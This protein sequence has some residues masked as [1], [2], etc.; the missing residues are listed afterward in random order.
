MRMKILTLVSV[1]SIAALAG[2]SSVTASTP[3]F[4]SDDPLLREPEPQDA[5]GAAP[6]Y[7]DLM[8]ELTYNLFALPRHKPSGVRAQNVN[9]IDEVPD[10]SWFTNRI[11]T[12]ALTIDEIVRGPAIG[13]PP[14]PSHWVI[15]RAKTS[16]SHA[17]FTAKDAKGDIWFLEFDPAYYPN[18]ATAAAVMGSKFY[19]ALGYNQVESYLT[20]FDPTADGESILKRRFFVPTASARRSRAP[21]SRSC[22]D[23]PPAGRMAHTA[24]LPAA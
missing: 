23:P 10:S 6:S 7:L 5:G 12:T 21:M 8:Y 15:W 20:T 16:G 22:S 2:F 3:R 13:P 24:C 14:D 9:T 4:Y 19:W 11:G 18:A 1:V 17:G